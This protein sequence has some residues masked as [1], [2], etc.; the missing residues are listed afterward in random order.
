MSALDP[1]G[2]STSVPAD[3]SQI[4]QLRRRLSQSARDSGADDAFAADLELVV[5]EL[6]TNVVQHTDSDTIRMSLRRDPHAWVLDVA[7]AAGLQSVSD[8]GPP[9]PDELTGRG[10]FIVQSLM[11]DLRLVDVNCHRVLRCTKHIP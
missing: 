3:V 7:D 11:D 4:A 6:A 2:T 9:D 5:S 1:D 8:L 10:L